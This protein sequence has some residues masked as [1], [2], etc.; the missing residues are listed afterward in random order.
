MR[1]KSTQRTLGS[2]LLAFES[3]VVFF[4]TLVAFGLKVA[5][6]PVVWAIGLS[7]AFILIATPAILGRKFSYVFGWFLQLVVVGLGI[8]VPL[9][10]VVGAIFVCLWAWAMIAGSTI[11]KARAVFEKN[12]AAGQPLEEEQ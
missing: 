6:G 5:D 9:M 1:K 2:M 10:Y 4:A 8:W 11:D 3:F 7:L 12:L